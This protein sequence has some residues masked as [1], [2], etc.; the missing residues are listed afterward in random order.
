MSTT[1]EDILGGL[2]DLFKGQKS[3][4]KVFDPKT[5]KWS[6]TTK[7]GD[8]FTSTGMKGLEL[9]LGVAGDIYDMNMA[10]KQY[11]LQKDKFEADKKL[12]ANKYNMSVERYNSNA[13]ASNNL[14]AQLMASG[15]TYHK[16]YDKYKT[17][18]LDKITM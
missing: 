7:Q 14:Y 10:N 15:D 4:I 3:T 6:S 1:L 17:K 12:S 9:G 18:E 16:D 13:R 11:N 5:N 2:G 8:I